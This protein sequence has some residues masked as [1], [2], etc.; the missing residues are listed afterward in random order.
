[1]E[2]AKAH[3]LVKKAGLYHRPEHVIGVR[4]IRPLSAVMDEVQ[5]IA[6]EKVAQARSFRRDLVKEASI[7]PDI[8]TVDSVLS[9]GF[10]NPENIRTFVGKLPYL[11][12]ALNTLCELTL[13]SRLGLNEVSE[14]AASRACRSLDEV[15]QGL[16]AL[17]MRS[18]DEREGSSV[19]S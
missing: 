13:L 6:E 4:D 15:I 8:Q 7:L 11:D 1:M 16:K 5:K 3:A 18:T 9:L 10:I 12:R 17:A 19:A 14:F 2:P